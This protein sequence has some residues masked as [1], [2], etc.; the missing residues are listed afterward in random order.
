[1]ENPVKKITLMLMMAVLGLLLAACGGAN[2]PKDQ[3]DVAM[4]DFMFTPNTFTIPAG[5]E[6]TVEARNEGAVVHNFVIMKQGTDVGENFGPEDEENVLWRI[7]VQPNGEATETF[8]APDQPGEYQLLCST[9]GHYM[10]GMVGKI[11][12]VAP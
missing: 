11:V 1:M 9:P 4:T 12:V 5:K 2:Q 3:I 6:I 8:T 7:E 10:A